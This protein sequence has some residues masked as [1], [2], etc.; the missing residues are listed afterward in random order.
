MFGR[1]KRKKEETYRRTITLVG[2]IQRGVFSQLQPG[3]VER[4]GQIEGG[5]LAQEVVD[6]LFG[7]LSPGNGHDTVLANQ[8]ATEVA[9]DNQNIRDAAF[10][11]LRA[12]LEVEGGKKN[13]AA[14]RRIL[15]T[16]HWLKQFGEIPPD[17]SE[18]QAL[19]RISEV[20]SQNGEKRSGTNH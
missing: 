16:I 3:F 12:M 15:D 6:K 13:F 2:A 17:A 19:N 20:F 7:R 1:E 14:E 5:R 8:S 18:P 10:I 11:S 9:R 4:H